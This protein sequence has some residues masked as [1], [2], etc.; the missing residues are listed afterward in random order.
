MVCNSPMQI[1]QGMRFYYKCSAVGGAPSPHMHGGGCCC[2]VTSYLICSALGCVQQPCAGIAGDAA[3]KVRL[4]VGLIEDKRMEYLAY[5]T[6]PPLDCMK[7]TI[8]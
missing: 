5:C 4:S 1:W 3:V 6:P 2:W 7:I 8:G